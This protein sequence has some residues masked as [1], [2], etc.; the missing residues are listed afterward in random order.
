MAFVSE[1]TIGPYLESGLNH[2]AL[3]YWRKTNP[4]PAFRKQYVRAVEMLVWQVKEGAPWTFNNSGYHLNF[5]EGKVLAGF[6][7]AN[8]EPRF[9]PTQK[10][11]WLMHS[12][13]GCHTNPG[14]TILDPFTG[15]GTTLVAA[16]AQGRKA[17]G[18]ELDER[19]AQAAAERLAQH[20][21]FDEPT[22]PAPPIDDLQGELLP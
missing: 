8:G 10:P 7:V 22:N 5:Y 13:I 2:R 12:L 1:F 11:L 6:A 15:S 9:H 19:Y 14:D 21:I 20:S 16:K 18:F 4:V 17:I 3:L